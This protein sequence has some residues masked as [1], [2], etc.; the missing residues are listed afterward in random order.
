MA[1]TEFVICKCSHCAGPLQFDSAQFQKV[2]EIEGLDLGQIVTCP[3]CSGDTQ[4]YIGAKHRKGPASIHGSQLATQRQVDYI[5][6][7]GGEVQDGMTK[8][9]AHDLIDQLLSGAIPATNRQLMVLRFWNRMDLA[10]QHR[11]DVTAWLDQLYRENPLYEAAWKYFKLDYK[12][13][14]SQR[15]PSWVPLGAGYIYLKQIRR[16]R[17]LVASIPTAVL[18]VLVI[19]LL[20]LVRHYLL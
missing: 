17:M 8:S 12:D 4:V 5:I 18:V 10:S 15:D 14:G 20:L 11:R 2:G 19:V 6:D 3:H 13:D 16:N 1:K 9:E 7:L